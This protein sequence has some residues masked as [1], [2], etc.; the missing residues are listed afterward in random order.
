[1]RSRLA[2]NNTA[3]TSGISRM[4]PGFS[5][6]EMLAAMTI[7]AMVLVAIL[8]I[9][10]RAE[11][12]AAAVTRR[13]DNSRTPR[14]ILQRISEDLDRI[15]SS[16][17]DA[18]I[19]IQNKF[20]K[21]FPT[22]RLVISRTFRDRANREQKF[23]EIIWQTSYDFESLGEGLVLY[24]SHSGIAAEDKVIDKNKE[25]W[26]KELFVPL[27]GGV[28]FFRI[29]AFKGEELVDK[30][31]GALPTGI[32]VAISFAEPYK[33][34]DGTL[35]VPDEEKII[36]TIAVD[37]SRKIKFEVPAGTYAGDQEEAIPAEATE[38]EKTPTETPKKTEKVKR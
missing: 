6:A 1:M 32:E 27:C 4:L 5:L 20:D 31:S 19:T 2:N 10:N 8:S 34:V 37:K 11:R 23:E 12:S 30:W 33:R 26:E 22:A 14:E 15:I 38:G 16:G 13:L 29:S 36:R 7:G 28:T 3:E 25:D 17:T 18:E 21:L 24:R 9:Y 35:D